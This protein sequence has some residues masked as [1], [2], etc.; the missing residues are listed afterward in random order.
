MH[1]QAWL[2]VAALL[3][4][5]PGPDMAVVTRSAL[6]RGFG[7]AV[8]T[9]LGIVA[10]LLAWA[11]AA[12]VGVAA[13]FNASAEAFTAL[14]LVG[15]AFLL[16]LGLQAWRAK[17]TGEVLPP[18]EAGRGNF[19]RGLLTNL[20]NPKIGVFYSTVLPQF[21]NQHHS[22]FLQSLALAAIHGILGLIW[23]PLYARFV[24][25]TGDLLR[26]PKARKILDRITG[27]VLIGLGLR[28][29]LER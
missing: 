12:A 6:E 1:W 14:K 10:G 7:P 5:T 8:W 17:H 29:A 25:K 16:Y 26:R 9:T 11:A 20:L 4:I 13:I 24:V 21:V 3:T 28:V 23:L 18:E 22:V 27:T 2:G 15:A 19:R